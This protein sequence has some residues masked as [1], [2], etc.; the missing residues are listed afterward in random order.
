VFGGGNTG[1]WAHVGGFVFGLAIAGGLMFFKV[2]D[3]IDPTLVDVLSGRPLERTQYDL[4]ELASM[5]LPPSEAAVKPQKAA[6][7]SSLQK[8]N[9]R[10][11][12][13]QAAPTISRRES[14]PVLR[15]TNIVQKGNDLVIF[16]V[17]DG[18]PVRE[19]SVATSEGAS[20]SLQPTK[21]LARREMGTMRLPNVNR[22]SLSTVTINITY[23]DQFE[24]RNKQL[25]FDEAKQRF[26]V[27]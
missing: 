5:P 17:N 10:P 26:T 15:V 19:L 14:L 8:A 6:A 2:I 27:Q 4:N 7:Q 11:A 13:V 16:F 22:Q 18:D 9:V 24:K 20:A 21:Q 3:T 12:G 23:S 1:Y 25:V